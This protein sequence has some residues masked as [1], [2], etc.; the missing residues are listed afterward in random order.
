MTTTPTVTGP[1]SAPRPTS[2]MPAST[3]WPSRCRARST[4]R[5]GRRGPV[6]LTARPPLRARSAKVSSWSESQPARPRGH[7]IAT[8]RP[9]MSS[10]GHRA[11]RAGARR[12]VEARVLGV[13]AVV[14]HDPHVPG[15][16]GDVEVH[17]AGHV[18]RLE[19]GLGDLDAVDRQL[20]V[21]RAAHDVVAGQADDPL[22]EV[23]LGLG[24]QQADEDQ[25]VVDRP[26]DAAALDR[27]R[28]LEPAARVL[29]DDDVAVLEVD[30]AGRQLR[31]DDPV[32]DEEGVLHRPR[33]DE[34][35][36]QQPGL[37]DEGQHQGHDDD[38]DD[39]AHRGG[40]HAAA[41]PAVPRSSSASCRPSSGPR[42][43]GVRTAYLGPSWPSATGSVSGALTGPPRAGGTVPNR[44][45]GQTRSTT[46]PTTASRGTVDGHGSGEGH[47][48]R[49]GGA[50]DGELAAGRRCRRAAGRPPTTGRARSRPSATGVE[51]STGGRGRRVD[52]D[53]V[54]GVGGGPHLPH[55]D[56][57]SWFDGRRERGRGDEVR[58]EDERLHQRGGDDRGPEE[59]DQPGTTRPGLGHGGGRCRVGV[60]SGGHPA[61]P[62]RPVWD[63]RTGTGSSQRA[64]GVSRFS[65]ILAALPRRS[66]R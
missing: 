45:S 8:A 22:D 10:I 56:T 40:D 9:V 11:V 1:A 66:R 19:V 6:G 51:R 61:E 50:D 36:L 62:S 17:R 28:D 54:T 32:A 3:R 37:D 43:V 39:L 24:G 49:R 63:G 35:G 2:S 29:E 33:G 15:G 46:V 30:R 65:L 59:H 21:L 26:G 12:V 34:E 38:H 58:L 27:R 42:P 57:V 20:A 16:H 14:A 41:G 31:D 18:A 60:G 55:E 48:I 13:G 7:T 52:D 53:E 25:P 23:V 64:T 44:L 5:L 47:G 4:R